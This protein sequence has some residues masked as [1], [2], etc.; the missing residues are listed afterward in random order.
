MAEIAITEFSDPACPWA[1]SAEPALRRV[2]WLYGEHLRWQTRMVVLSESVDSYAG[3]GFTPERLAAALV[4]FAEEYG[5]PIETG[6]RARMSA[7]LPACAAVVAARLNAPEFERPLLRALR[8]HNFGGD[9][10][11]DPL[12]IASA[13]EDVGLDPAELADW[14]ATAEVEE[15]LRED[16]AAARHPLPA[17]LVLD[18]KLASWSGGRRYTCPS[19]E[20]SRADGG[21]PEAVPGFQ[22]A[23]AYEVVLANVAP[24]IARREPPS[25]V[26]EVLAWAGT[27]LATAE[28]AA[29]CEIST[30]EAREQL[31]SVA[32][33]RPFGTDSFWSLDA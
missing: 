6:V 25:S 10:L 7:T 18:H 22:P 13:A 28:L 26:E 1:Y 12:T 4:H 32:V 19:L 17:A 21:V 15:A 33:E 9:L 30:E 8:L 24:E 14:S 29:V 16:M 31:A 20:I 3:S 27:P 23:A 11:D 5:M 2:E